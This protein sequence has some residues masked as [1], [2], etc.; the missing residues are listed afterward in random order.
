M[1]PKQNELFQSTVL[2]IAEMLITKLFRH[3]QVYV[4]NKI[5]IESSLLFRESVSYCSFCKAADGTHFVRN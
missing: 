1:Q 2:I 4:E 3:K 5:C